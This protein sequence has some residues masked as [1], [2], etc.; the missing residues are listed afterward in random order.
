MGIDYASEKFTTAIY[1]ILT[2]AVTESPQDRVYIAAMATRNLRPEDFTPVLWERFAK[3]QIAV[4]RI[5]DETK[6]SFRA[7]ADSLTAMEAHNLL[8]EFFNLANDV[9]EEYRVRYGQKGK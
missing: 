6:D 8:V 1:S 7:T 5:N 4:T 3:F 9:E 2:S